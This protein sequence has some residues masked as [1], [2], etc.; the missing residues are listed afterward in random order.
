MVYDQLKSINPDVHVL[1]ITGGNQ[2]AVSGIKPKEGE[3]FLQ[4]PFSLT[5]LSSVIGDIS[6]RNQY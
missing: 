4:K 5:A 3:P 6:Q 2:D 1:F